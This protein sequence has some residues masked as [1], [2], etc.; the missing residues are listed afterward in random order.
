[1]SSMKKTILC[2]I[3]IIILGILFVKSPLWGGIAVGFTILAVFIFK[4]IDANTSDGENDKFE[5]SEESSKKLEKSKKLL[6]YATAILAFLSFFT[7]TQGMKN[8]VFSTEW[9]A[10][11]GSFAVQSI[12]IV[13]SLFLCN[14]FVA[15]KGNHILS[16]RIKLVIKSALVVFFSISLIVSS[17]F[18]YSYIANTAYRDIR[19]SDYETIIQSFLITESHRLRTENS[20]IG[21]ILFDNISG[22]LN[23]DLKGVIDEFVVEENNDL[24]TQ[25]R[26]INLDVYQSEEFPVVNILDEYIEKNKWGAQA[27][28]LLDRYN[29]ERRNYQ[30]Y[31]D[32]YKII[33]DSITKAVQD[34]KTENM[35]TILKSFENALTNLGKLKKNVNISIKSMDDWYSYNINR[36][37]S[38]QRSEIQEIY[39]KFLIEI[40]N[41]ETKLHE[42]L[43]QNSVPTTELTTSTDNLKTQYEMILK[44]I[45]F[46]ELETNPDAVKIAED[47]STLMMDAASQGVLS[48][49][50][51]VELQ[52][53]KEKLLEYDKYL[54]LKTDL[55]YYINEKLNMTQMSSMTSSDAAAASDAADMKINYVEDSEWKNRRND[56]F[57]DFLLLLQS[58]PEIENMELEHSDYDADAV[59]HEA[60][61]LRRDLLG[62]LTDFE[63]AF[64][65]FKYDFKVMAIFSAFIAVFFDLGSFMTGVF[66][67][68]IDYIPRK[69][70]DKTK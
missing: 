53:L 61:T 65:F 66:L 1:M 29:K 44:R 28:D 27:K 26:L 55:D 37:I 47:L 17:T 67:F 42:C 12:L 22:E 38:S 9:L 10:Y 25:I 49:N 57:S 21:K 45:A 62:E 43:S 40:E 2:N 46:L 30:E 56:D 3:V 69:K 20:R 33:R 23:S 24:M 4:F 16:S 58:L 60:Q 41:A 13:F 39:S 54:Q 64:D 36:D 48:S 31:V 35:E 34:V 15:I 51:I 32:N 14:F 5:I 50:N 11:L 8:F 70:G 59:I 6:R 52:N 68:A 18:S 63:R 19:D 7:T